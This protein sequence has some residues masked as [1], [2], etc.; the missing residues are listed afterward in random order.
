[1]DFGYE[2]QMLG[3]NLKAR[4]NEGEVYGNAAIV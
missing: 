2:F 1:M 3:L 4:Q